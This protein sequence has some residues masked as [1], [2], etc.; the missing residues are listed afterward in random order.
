MNQYQRENLIN[1][2]AARVHQAWC[3]GELKAFYDRLVVELKNTDRP[4]VAFGNACYKNGKKRNEV[5]L[6][7]DYLMAHNTW[8]LNKLKTYSGFKYMS[9]TD[10]T[11]CV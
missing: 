4:G 10:G 9:V 6:D 2:S 11:I 1:Q 8:A 3:E 5:E 7:S